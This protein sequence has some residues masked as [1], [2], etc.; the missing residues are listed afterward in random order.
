M[1]RNRSYNNRRPGYKACGKMVYGDAK[2]ALAI[3]RSV[4]SLMNVE[5][6]NHDVDHSATAIADGVGNI[7]QLTN[8]PQGDTTITRDGSNCKITSVYINL[9]LRINASATNTNVRVSLV[10]DKQTNQAIYATAD[11]L[12]NVN[13]VNSIVSPLNLDNQYR[14]HILYNKVFKITDSGQ[15]TAVVKIY[16]KMQMKLR[17]DGNTPSIA[18]LR[19]GSLSLL[20]ISNE[21]TNTPTFTGS[22]RIRFVD[23]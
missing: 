8:I 6:K 18:D 16:K 4:K 13:N 12:S 9:L 2:K 17:F 7:V 22:C 1:P 5:F 10:H 11:L 14:F 19:S 20:L 23:N 15:Q 21:A 3:A